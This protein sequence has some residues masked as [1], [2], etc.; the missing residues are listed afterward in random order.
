MRFSEIASRLTGIS[1]PVL[2]VSWNPSTADS[3]VA[4]KVITFV[5][6]KRVLYNPFEVEV[7]EHCVASV[8]DIR[9]FLTATMAEHGQADELQE[10]LRAMRAACRKFLDEIHINPEAKR[11]TIPRLSSAYAFTNPVLN[12]ALGELRGVFGI[13]VAQIAVKY[14]LDVEDQ[15]AA[16]FPYP[17][18]EE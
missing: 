6:N 12:Q 7:P 2:G 13:H 16:I 10:H 4:K 11:L 8:L 15:L 5:E 17:S 3:A 1:T 18:T 9:Q 14:K